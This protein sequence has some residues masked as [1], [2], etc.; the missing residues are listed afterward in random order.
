MDQNIKLNTIAYR[1]VFI[2]LLKNEMCS[3]HGYESTIKNSS[4]NELYLTKRTHQ[5]PTV[6]SCQEGV[7]YTH[8]C[9]KY[10]NYLHYLHHFTLF[11]FCFSF[12][13]YIT[14]NIKSR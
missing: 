1:L 2:W 11:I 3:F 13:N 8:H 14:W 9:Q 5:K 10:S 12:S 6:M 4:Q 7:R